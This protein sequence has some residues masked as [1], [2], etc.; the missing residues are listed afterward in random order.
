MTDLDRVSDVC[1][2]PV[3]DQPLRLA[4]FQ[5]L[6]KAA[7]RPAERLAPLHLRVTVPGGE[8]VAAAVRDLAE[9]ET[10]C[11]SFFTFSVSTPQPGAVVLDIEVLADHREVLDSL[12]AHASAARSRS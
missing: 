5:A 1:T 3:A 4:E 11:C 6:W 8:D 2:L 10:R 7:V 12:E 9:R